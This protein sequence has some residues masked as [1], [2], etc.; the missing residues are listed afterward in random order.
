MGKPHSEVKPQTPLYFDAPISQF[1]GIKPN[2]L[3]VDV[4]VDAVIHEISTNIRLKGDIEDCREALFADIDNNERGSKG[5]LETPEYSEAKKQLPA[6]TFGGT[7]K[8]RNN[9][10]L[11]QFSG[12]L[13]FDI[14]FDKSQSVID[15]ESERSK[16]RIIYNRLKKDKYVS[17]LFGS[18][19]G[20]GVKGLVKIPAVS[21]D[22]EYKSYFRGWQKYVKDTYGVDLDSLPDIARLCFLSYQKEPHVNRDS[23]VF[24]ATIQTPQHKESA[25]V[26]THTDASIKAAI[27]VLKRTGI[28]ED[29]DRNT[30]VGLC[31]A[32]KRGGISYQDFDGIMQKTAGYD[33]QEN[34]R[35]W[36]TVDLAE[37]PGMMTVAS[38]VKYAKDA[39]KRLYLEIRKDI[40][41]S[42]EEEPEA[43]GLATAIERKLARRYAF[44]LNTITD[45]IF[46]KLGDNEE[47]MSDYIEAEMRCWLLDQGF[48]RRDAITD[49]V[50][51]AAYKHRFNPVQ[52]Y[53]KRLKWDDEDHIETLCQ[54]FADNDKIFQELFSAWC[55]GA[56]RRV[57]TGRHHQAII[58]VGKQGKGKSFFARWLCPLKLYHIEAPIRPDANDDKIRMT[59][60]FIWEIAEMGATTRR[61]DIEALKHFISQEDSVFRRAHDKYDQRKAAIASYIGT[62]NHDGSGF[63]NDPTGHRR[64]WPIEIQSIDWAY[65]DKV[66]VNQ[67][68]AQAYQLWKDEQDAG[69]E[70]F[71]TI[72]PETQA[73][74]NRNIENDFSVG[75]P[76][77]NLLMR[78]L[79][80]TGRKEDFMDTAEI[81][82]TLER[83]GYKR[84]NQ[85]TD[86]MYVNK[87]MRQ[88]QEKGFSVTKGRNGRTGPRGFL[89]IRPIDAKGSDW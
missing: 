65:V 77:E 21:T 46:V 68:W 2:P 81:L 86:E 84:G 62:V 63:L 40:K 32:C 66:D 38:L 53:F 52:E 34:F 76:V 6:V 28:K 17:L 85:R 16:I 43:P 87:A 74:I 27:T 33:K 37:R 20:I 67:V 26:D 89:G 31:A 23:E 35:I 36:N 72:R 49:V 14:D 1:D 75:D 10:Q 7:F 29:L 3:N 88:L 41:K 50:R 51:K 56:V 19:S 70:C 64:W 48:S 45:K 15:Y 13:S 54:H 78:C 25:P 59:E 55:V 24:T 60:N 82:V 44:R 22:S 18:V 83:N 47:M 39:D 42:G 11:Q 8:Q 69:S 58:F 73:I 80:Y 61:A 5:K 12:F 71:S 57:F 30:F 79:E 4:T 9:T